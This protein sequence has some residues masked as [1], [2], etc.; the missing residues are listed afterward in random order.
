MEA[1]CWLLTDGLQVRILPGEPTSPSSSIIY[2][3]RFPSPPMSLSRDGQ[4]VAYIELR[5]AAGYDNWVLRLSDRKSQP[6][7]QMPSNESAPR[8]SPDGHWIAYI[9][10]ESGHFVVYGQP[11]PGPSE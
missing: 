9:S 5:P 6:F 3:H 4:L 10:D 7:P 8:F 2:G 1:L 11:H